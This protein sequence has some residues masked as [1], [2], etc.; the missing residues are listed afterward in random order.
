MALCLAGPVN[1]NTLAWDTILDVNHN[2][3]IF[4]HAQRRSGVLSVDKVV[5]IGPSSATSELPGIDSASR[6]SVANYTF[7]IH[8][9]IKQAERIIF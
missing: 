6:F 1:R 4:A 2:E 3:I 9:V 7:M 8:S 5:V